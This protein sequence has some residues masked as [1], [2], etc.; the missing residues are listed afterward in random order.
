VVLV[1]VLELVMEEHDE[2]GVAE[3]DGGWNAIMDFR[4]EVL[5]LA[6]VSPFCFE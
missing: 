5:L 1:V 3:L 2:G 6:E 4:E